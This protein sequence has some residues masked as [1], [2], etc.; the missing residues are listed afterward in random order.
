[1]AQVYYGVNLGQH[2][3]AV[4][5]ATSTNSTDVELRVDTSKIASREQLNE[6]VDTLVQQVGKQNFPFA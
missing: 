1:M 2:D 5:I 6:L 3:D 4:A